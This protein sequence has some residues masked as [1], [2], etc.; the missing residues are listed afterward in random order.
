MKS[1]IE[2]YKESIKRVQ[3][4]IEQGECHPSWGK[5]LRGRYEKA[6]D[7]KQKALEKKRK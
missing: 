4:A 7:K 6:I 1:R 5:N 2:Q 3:R